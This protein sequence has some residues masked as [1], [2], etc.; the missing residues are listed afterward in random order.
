M[1]IAYKDLS[2]DALRGVIEEYI[3]REGTDYGPQDYTLAAKVEQVMR[4]LERGE[5][6]IYFDAESETCTLA[7]P[8]QMRD[9]LAKQNEE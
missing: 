1:E 8:Q 7:T 5:V 6:K 2:P 9:T 3:G 4:Q